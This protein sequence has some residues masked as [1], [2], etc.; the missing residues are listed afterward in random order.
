VAEHDLTHDADPDVALDWFGHPIHADGGLLAEPVPCPYCG[1]TFRRAAL[2]DAHLG[3]AHHYRRTGGQT[4][5]VS[6]R[7]E[8]WVRGL[9][10]L[11]LWF[12]L[13]LNAALTTILY[14]AWGADL[15][16]FSLDSQ[17]PVLKTWIVRLSILPSVLLMSWRVVDKRV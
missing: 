13:P 8:R 14:L 5:A 10:F 9:V 16:M 6:V 11:P 1:T 2:L 15:T 3:E 4:R 17:L 12:V 7:L